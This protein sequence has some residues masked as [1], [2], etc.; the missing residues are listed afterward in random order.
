RRTRHAGQDHREGASGG[1]YSRRHCAC[2]R[3]LSRCATR[4]RRALHRRLRAPWSLELRGGVVR[5]PCGS[6]RMS[7]LIDLDGNIRTDSWVFVADQAPAPPAGDIVVSMARL[8]RESGELLSRAGGLGVRMAPSD[9]VESIAELL[10]RL[11]LVEIDFPAF[12][13][14][15]GFS[16]A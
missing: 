3:A 15:R 13:D 6:R 5:G 8:M 12:R 11:D 4:R 10:P 16:S 1:R 9:A 14:G 2:R 7:V